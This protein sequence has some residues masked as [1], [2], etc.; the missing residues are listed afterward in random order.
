MEWIYALRCEKDYYYIGKTNN[1]E[2]RF[3]DHVEGKFGSKWTQLHPPI[4]IVESFKMENKFDESRKTLEYMEKYGISKVRGA[5]WCNARLT[6]AQREEIQRY[7]QPDACFHCGQEGHF[8]A[9]CDEWGTSSSDSESAFCS[10][11]EQDGHYADECTMTRSGKKRKMDMRYKECDRC[12]STTHFEDECYAE[13]DIDGKFLGC[14][15]C[16]RNSHARKNCYATF[17]IDGS[18]LDCARCGRNTHS[19]ETC[20]AKTDIDGWSID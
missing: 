13:Y 9:D 14:S 7:L 8:A 12:G 17:H 3:A 19:A 2:R 5:Q 20:Y 1:I 10:K 18:V 15:R 16:G 6:K 11:C 4:K